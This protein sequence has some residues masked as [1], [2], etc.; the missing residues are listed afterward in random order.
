MVL[1][2]QTLPAQVLLGLYLGVLTGLFPALV[3]WGLGFI[4]R[5][6]T[7]VTVPGTVVMVLAVALA[8]VNGGLLGLLDESFI[9]SPAALV[10]LLVV[11]MMAMYAHAQGDRMGE[12]FPHRIT[13]TGLRERTLSMDVVERVGAFGRV[14]VRVTGD[15]DDI[16]GYPPLP[17]DVRAAIR[18]GDWTFPADL[19]LSALESRLADRLRTEFELAEVTVSIDESGRATVSGA[20]APGRLSRRV[21][22]GKR[23][24]SVRTLLPTGLAQGD[25]VEVDLPDGSLSATVASAASDVASVDAK[26]PETDGGE[27][28]AEAAE[29]PP[30]GAPT[31][32]GGEGRV[33]LAVSRPEA[34]RLLGVEYAPVRVRSRGV[35][36]EFELVTLLKQTGREFRQATVRSGGPLDEVTLGEARIRDDYGVAVLAVKRPSGWVVAP[37]GTTHLEAG[38]DVFV[39]GS[40]ADLRRF[41][42]AVA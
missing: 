9:A 25:V 37:R 33:T 14:R 36:R 18:D 2:S 35:R 1:S 32:T 13:L 5:Y 42:E 40:R 23:A 31:T 3:A 12:T 38:D 15:V 8:G 30:Q 29:E 22:A 11:M 16:E 34:R 19:P 20:P 17:D 41:T 6:F 10:A 24:V 28:H 7:G 4:F 26:P 39:A 27:T 21:P